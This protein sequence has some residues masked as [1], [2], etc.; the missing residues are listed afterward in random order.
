M[1]TELT[2]ILTRVKDLFTIIGPSTIAVIVGVSILG[3]FLN[4]N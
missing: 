3:F 1:S 4:R 2:Q